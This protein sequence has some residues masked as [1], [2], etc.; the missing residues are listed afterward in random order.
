MV[1]LVW[2]T[3]NVV[4]VHLGIIASGLNDL[5]DSA[6]KA[7]GDARVSV[8][9]VFFDPAVE[10]RILNA[11]KSH[12]LAQTGTKV[13]VEAPVMFEAIRPFL[14]ALRVEPESLPF[15]RYLVHRSDD[16]LRSIKISPPQYA[17]V[18]GFTYQLASLFPP[19]AGVD[20]LKLDVSDPTSI[21]FVRAQ[22]K[23]SRLDASQGEAV[24][25]TLTRE[26]AMIQ[27]Y[28]FLLS[29]SSFKH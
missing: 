22:L 28:C 24:V 23:M 1:G 26:L 4:D 29:S 27:G 16:F 3:G 15:A 20:D 7:N 25:D 10:V 6:G 8:R 9:V 13:L 14:E 11:L 19:E 17:L 5:R 12:D 21:A 2:Q 18:P